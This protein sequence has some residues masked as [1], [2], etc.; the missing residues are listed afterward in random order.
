MRSGVTECVWRHAPEE[1]GGFGKILEKSV[2]WELDTERDGWL[3]L[4]RGDLCGGCHTCWWGGVRWKS[5]NRKIV[6]LTLCRITFKLKGNKKVRTWTKKSLRVFRV[7]R[8]YVQSDM[9]Y[10]YIYMNIICPFRIF[11]YM[12]MVHM[13]QIM[14]NQLN[15]V[16]DFQECGFS[17][18]LFWKKLI[19]R[20]S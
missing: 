6:P 20:L 7:S 16:K 19:Y 8:S 2:S 4:A 13:E 11:M 15:V 17:N 12:A 14:L 10:I 9:C 18:E 1:R 3:S 5:Q